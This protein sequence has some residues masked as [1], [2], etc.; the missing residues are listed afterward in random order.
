MVGEAGG[1][2]G[3]GEQEAAPGILILHHSSEI[4]DKIKK[5]VFNSVADPDPRCL[6]DPW[7]RDC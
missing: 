7:M 4:R 5:I 6:C 1:G 3:G 2:G